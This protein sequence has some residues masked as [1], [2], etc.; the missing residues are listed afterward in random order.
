MKKSVITAAI[1]FGMAISGCG[2]SSDASNGSAS[3]GSAVAKED[4]CTLLTTA[5]V[6]QLVGE[7]VHDGKRDTKHTYPNSS[8]CTWTSV[9][10]DMPLLILTYN[11]HAASHDLAYYA[12]PGNAVKKLNS[13]PNE[14]VAVLTS[15]Q[16]LF[17]VIVRSGNNA[18]LLIAPYLKVKEGS[19]KWKNEVKLT[20]LAAERAKKRE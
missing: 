7:A 9:S 10:H 5:E 18:I 1:L 6:S 11:Q 2:A 17:E 14:A 3:K 15:K 4:V 19:D 12:P 13:A 20:D 16:N 8:A